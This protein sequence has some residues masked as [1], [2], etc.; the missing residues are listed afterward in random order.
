MKLH[1][2]FSILW[3]KNLNIW[4]PSF[5]R[6]ENDSEIIIKYCSRNSYQSKVNTSAAREVTN[7]SNIKFVLA[8]KVFEYEVSEAKTIK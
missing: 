5:Q 7:G 8:L 4:L 3:F 2:H 6:M 1:L